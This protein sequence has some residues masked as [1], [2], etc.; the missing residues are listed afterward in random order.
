M[1]NGYC[2]TSLRFALNRLRKILICT[3]TAAAGLVSANKS[4]FS[5]VPG[6]ISVDQ[7][8]AVCLKFFESCGIEAPTEPPTVMRMT[9]TPKRGGVFGFNFVG[10]ASVSVNAV[11][12][13][14][15]M[16]VNASRIDEKLAG[17]KT[18][19]HALLTNDLAARIYIKNLAKK[20]G[21]GD[22]Y[23]LVELVARYP[24]ETNQSDAS[25]RAIFQA[26]PYDYRLRYPWGERQI[27]VDPWDGVVVS[28][29]TYPD[30]KYK[31]ESHE[32]KITIREARDKAGSVVEKYSIGKIRDAA[33]ADRAKPATITMRSGLMYVAP[34]GLFD[35]FKYELTD[36]VFRLRLAWV[37]FYAYDE[38]VWIDAADGRVLGGMLYDPSGARLKKPKQ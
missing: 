6:E 14:I 11:T 36:G 31:I 19:E 37:L 25:V 13:E 24:S 1:K 5:R 35:G 34:N 27:S 8:L 3:A 4:D 38:E 17:F 7:A 10:R 9:K 18:P 26:K 21:I 29:S 23:K 20:M 12:G 32:A 2:G 30:A 15:T 28:Y 16:F 33:Y 22:D